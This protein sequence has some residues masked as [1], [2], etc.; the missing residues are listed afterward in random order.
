MK[1]ILAA[2]MFLTLLGAP[3]LAN[4]CPTLIKK[5]QDALQSMSGMD[6]AMMQKAKDHIAKAQAEHDAGKH[7]EAIATANDALQLLKM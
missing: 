2:G 6:D 5:A 3:A 7:K 1:A 4:E